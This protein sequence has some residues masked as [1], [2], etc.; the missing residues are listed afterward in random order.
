MFWR[1]YSRAC[2]SVLVLL[3]TSTLAFAQEAQ[4]V[5]ITVGEKSKE[6]FTFEPKTVTVKPGKVQFTLVNKA[7][8]NHNLAIKLNDKDVRLARAEAGKSATSEPVEL[9]AGEYE[10]FCTFTTGGSHK[11]KGMV[12]KLTVK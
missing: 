8:N 7:E 1:R 10:I 4:K 5:T 3:F 12:G 6:V 11:E 9:A 2:F